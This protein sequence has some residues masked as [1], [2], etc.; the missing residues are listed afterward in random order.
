MVMSNYMTLA[1]YS[2]DAIYQWMFE[3]SL[4]AY[5]WVMVF[6]CYSMGS[7]SDEGF[8]MRKPYVSSSNYLVK[9]SNEGRGSWTEVW[10]ELFK[11]FV[12]RN[13]EV[14]SHTVLANFIKG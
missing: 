5:E 4:D 9:M 14:L 6:N 8:A 13:K 11:K 12:Q 3:F 7:W 1:G 10:D 2:P